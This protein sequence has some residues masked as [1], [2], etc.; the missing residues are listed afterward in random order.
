MVTVVDVFLAA[1]H[2]DVVDTCGSFVRSDGHR[3]DVPF[4]HDINP[5][6]VGGISVEVHVGYGGECICQSFLRCGESSPKAY[7][8]FVD[9]VEF[10]LESSLLYVEHLL[11]AFTRDGNVSQSAFPSGVERDSD[12]NRNIREGLGLRNGDPGNI[13]SRLYGHVRLDGKVDFTSFVGSVDVGSVDDYPVH[14][15]LDDGDCPG[16]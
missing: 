11:D 5:V 15:G 7:A 3:D 2:V 10:G 14:L 13:N 12:R 4:F 1:T 8:K 6:G 16:Q 9:E